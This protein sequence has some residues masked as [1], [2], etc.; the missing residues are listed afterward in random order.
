MDGIIERAPFRLWR[1]QRSLVLFHIVR[2]CDRSILRGGGHTRISIPLLSGQVRLHTYHGH[3]HLLLGIF[4]PEQCFALTIHIRLFGGA[5]GVVVCCAR[6]LGQLVGLPPLPRS[7]QYGW[8]TSVDS[9]RCSG[10]IVFADC[11]IPDLCK[12]QRDHFGSTKPRCL[13]NRCSQRRTALS[14]PLSRATSL[15]RRG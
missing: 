8:L 14:V 3:Y 11:D 6:D 15:V 5:L 9:G 4:P 2:S 10:F 1:I 7:L 13:T 12:T